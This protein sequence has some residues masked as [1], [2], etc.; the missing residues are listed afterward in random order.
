[1][2][3]HERWRLAG[4]ALRKFLRKKK[5]KYRRTFTE[6]ENDRPNEDGEFVL[7]DLSTTFGLNSIPF[8]ATSD[9]IEAYKLGQQSV[10]QYIV[11]QMDMSDA[12][13]RLLTKDADSDD[14]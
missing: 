12:Q 1:M 9:R 13:I 14:E 2:G 3:V 4:N 8:D 11:D 5:K 6:F 7:R 10:V